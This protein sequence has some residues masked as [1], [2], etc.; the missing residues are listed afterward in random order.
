MTRMTP[1]SLPALAA[2][3]LLAACGTLAPTLPQTGQDEAAVRA[4]M[5]EPTGRYTMPG[6][7][8]RLEYARGPAGRETWMV[9]LDAAGRVRAVEQVLN[10]RRF[11]EVVNGMPADDLLRVIGRPGRKA[12]EYQDRVTWYWRYP[13][14]DCLR[15]AVTLSA[16]GRVINGGSHMPD[17]SC[18]DRR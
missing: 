8:A 12:P 18:D 10:L 17:P 1:T 5:G 11:A 14:N 9:D 16:L 6:G 4:A 7:L 15:L 2:A 13:N 3:L